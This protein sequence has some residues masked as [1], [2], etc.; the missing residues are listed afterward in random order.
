MSKEKDNP[1]LERAMLTG[2]YRIAK[3]N[4]SYLSAQLIF[5][6]VCLYV[7]TFAAICVIHFIFG[8]NIGFTLEMIA[9][10]LLILTLFA[11]AFALFISTVLDRNTN[12]VT[13]GVSIV[14]CILAG[15]FIP[16]TANNPVI[17]SI[18]KAIPQTE[19]MNLVHGIEFGGHLH[20]YTGAIIYILLW[21]ALF[22]L[23]GTITAKNKIGKGIC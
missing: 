4:S 6:M 23:A 19:Y 15:C 11:T 12:L 13:S 18:C 5:T 2:I 22:L 7:P 14:T 1:Y 3:E 21:T 20:Q 9:L 16:I 8:A 17:T 10:L